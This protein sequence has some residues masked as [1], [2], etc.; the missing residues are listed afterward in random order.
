MGL[1]LDRACIAVL[2]ERKAGIDLSD[3]LPNT[4]KYSQP[5]DVFVQAEGQENQTAS[6]V[7]FPK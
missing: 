6:E 3:T 7:M 1:Q 5:L 4:S 2:H